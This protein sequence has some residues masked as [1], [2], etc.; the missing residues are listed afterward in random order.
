M[1]RLITQNIP[2]EPEVPE[3]TLLLFPK[4]YAHMMQQ[5]YNSVH[6][7]VQTKIDQVKTQQE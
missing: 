6:K 3:V 2:A 7:G 1:Q 5:L 4:G